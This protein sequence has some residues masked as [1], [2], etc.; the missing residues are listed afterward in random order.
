M[1]CRLTRLNSVHRNLR[2]DEIVGGCSGRPVTG[3]PFIM[4]STLLDSN[5]HVRL[6]ETT[7]VTKTTS[8]E[9]GK[10]IEFETK[11]S[12]YKWEHLVDPDSSEDRASVS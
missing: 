9:A 4:T 2:T 12:I 3:A 5:A 10:V 11:N 8:S 7:R 1:K 6:T